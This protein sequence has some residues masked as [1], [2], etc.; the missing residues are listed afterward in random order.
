MTDTPGKIH[1]TWE[2]SPELNQHPTLR[3]SYSVFFI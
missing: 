3:F 2:L 1:L